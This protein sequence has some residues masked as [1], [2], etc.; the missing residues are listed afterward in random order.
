MTSVNDL[1]LS[2][3]KIRPILLEE[4]SECEQ[5]RR[6]TERAYQALRDAGLFKIIA[7]KRFGG[8]EMH[9]TDALK[10]W[11][12]IARI[13]ASIGWNAFMTHAGV[14][15]FAAWLSERAV[16]EVYADG[17]PTMAGV[18]A[19]PLGTERV[20]G[21]WRI[22]GTSPFASGCQNVDWYVVPMSHET[23]PVFAGFIRARDGVVKDTWHTLGMR[24]TGSADYGAEGAFVP[25]HLTADPGP[26]ANPAPGMGG[27]LFRMFPWTPILAQ[28]IT[29]VAVAANAVDA[30]IDLCKK[31]IPTYQQ[32]ALQGQQ[33]AQFHLG[34]AAA[35]VEASRDTLYRASDFGY[36]DVERSGK[37][38]SNDA[39]VRLQLASSFA[40]EACAEATRLVNDVVGTSS[41]RLNQPFERWFRD[42]HTLIHHA[43]N[44]NRRYVDAGKLMLGLETDWI[45]L[46]F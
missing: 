40:G 27:P 22:T 25:D 10:I 15:P 9:P 37:S 16:Q 21:G 20:K 1:L 19:P 3:E 26:L 2:V 32:A 5:Q 38:L 14:P 4:A 7:P 43:A 24:G 8:L 23:R 44:S 31:K 28:A 29:S 33:L 18:F 34:K 39:K 42:A 35:L 30:A 45:F 12:A 36:A 11:E 41:I 46:T 17:I 6:V 13:D